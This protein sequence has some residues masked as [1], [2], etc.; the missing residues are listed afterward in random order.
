MSRPLRIEYS[1]ACYHVL[2]RG[3]RGDRIFADHGDCQ[4]F[5]NLLQESIEMWNVRICAYCLMQNH[6]HILLQTPDANISRCM[7]HINGVYTQRYNRRHGCD[8]PLFRG[9]YKAILIDG[10]SYLLQLVR[11]IHRNPLRAGIVQSM[12]KYLWSS[13][14]GYLSDVEKWDWLDKAF[15]FSIFSQDTRQAKRAYKRFINLEDSKD[16][17]D[18]FER[19]KLPSVFGSDKFISWVKEKFLGEK[20]HHEVPDSS[21]LVPEISKIKAVIC[22]YYS[23]REKDLLI[24]KRGVFNEPRLVAIYLI[25]LFRKDGL[26]R[27]S[28]EF[29][30]KGYSSASSAIDR[31]K[32][33]MVSDREL[34][35]RVDAVKDLIVKG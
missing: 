9:R 13:H 31:L 1:N 17:Q 12:D 34:K 29:S 7:R 30:M 22:E 5:V 6:Y 26:S 16:V 23:I 28:Q 10:D 35:T 8:G 33:K 3:R 24:P 2:N 14:R 18:I 20:N 21:F 4:A 25:R 27:I 32:K 11:Y 15:I 19:N